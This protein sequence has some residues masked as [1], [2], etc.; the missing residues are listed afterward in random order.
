MMKWS[1]STYFTYKVN[2]FFG[3][4]F[5]LITF[6]IVWELKISVPLCITIK[7]GLIFL[8]SWSQSHVLLQ[9]VQNVVCYCPAKISKTSERQHMVLLNL[10]TFFQQVELSQMCGLP[11]PRAL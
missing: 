3:I 7:K 4:T 2:I 9:H 1:E 11:M 5:F 10:F 6:L 8:L